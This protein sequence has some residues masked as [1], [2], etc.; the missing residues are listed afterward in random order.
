VRSQRLG[1]ALSG[2]DGP[3]ELSWREWEVLDLLR[4]G[5]S[6][7]EIANRLSLSAVTV[8][9]HACSVGKKLGVSSRAEAVAFVAESGIPTNRRRLAPTAGAAAAS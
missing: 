5:M 7:G 8:R 2:R 3:G 9:R 1:R 4:S 6:T